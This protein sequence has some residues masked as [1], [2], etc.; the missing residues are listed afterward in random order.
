RA[1]I[2]EA[3]NSTFGEERVTGDVRVDEDVGDAAWVDHLDAL[4]MALDTPGAVV[5]LTGD[6]ARVTGR[7]TGEARANLADR[8]RDAL[9]GTAAVAADTTD[10]AEEEAGEP[11][12]GGGDRAGGVEETAP[13]SGSG[14]P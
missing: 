5:V 11:G 2:A 1:T 8:I 3:L 12:N 6:S 7:L 9:G 10:G 13:G 14:S 4:L